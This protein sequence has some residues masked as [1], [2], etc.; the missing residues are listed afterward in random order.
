[1]PSLTKRD[2]VNAVFEKTGIPL[3]HVR[4]AVQLTLD[5]IVGALAQGRG[6]E[7][8]NF[9]VFDIQIRRPRVGRNPN[10]PE[11]EVQ[12]P[13]RAS[14]KFKLGK[15][16]KALMQSFDEAKLDE[17]EAESLKTKRGPRKKN[18]VK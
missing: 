10:K 11:W 4:N 13:R 1:M 12:I 3:K 2:I 5:E 9:G 18:R 14:V 7:L 16:L 6:V 17:I 8:R 15:E